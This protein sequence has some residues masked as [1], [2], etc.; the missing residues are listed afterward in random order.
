MSNVVSDTERKEHEMK[1]L[2]AIAGLSLFLNCLAGAQ[3]EP[4]FKAPVLVVTPSA[5]D[6]GAVEKNTTVT[7]TFLVENVG[8]STFEMNAAVSGPFRI[9]S[10][11]SYSLEPRT[12][13]VVTIAYTPSGAPIDKEIVLC[14]GAGGARVVVMGRPAT[15]L[16]SDLE[17]WRLVA[18]HDLDE[19]D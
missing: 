18:P 12:V 13:G 10:G 19:S 1:T 8:G 14:T 3:T 7:N 2:A 15:A 4:L 5:V 6:F 9:V 17:R 11:G 16:P